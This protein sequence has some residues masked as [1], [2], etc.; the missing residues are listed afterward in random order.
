MIKET[1]VDREPKSWCGCSSPDVRLIASTV[2]YASDGTGFGILICDE[3][4]SRREVE[5]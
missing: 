5:L 1:E 2:R 3:C 4:K